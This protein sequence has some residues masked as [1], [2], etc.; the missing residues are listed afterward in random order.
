VVRRSVLPERPGPGCPER[1]CPG[2][3]RSAAEV[4]A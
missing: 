3:V 4:V 1:E 2:T